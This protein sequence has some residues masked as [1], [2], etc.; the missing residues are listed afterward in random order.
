MQ[1]YKNIKKKIYI[2]S[3]VLVLMLSVGLYFAFSSYDR[4]ANADFPVQC[5]HNYVKEQESHI[6]CSP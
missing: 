1:E 3:F 2:I 5:I 6:S 4:K